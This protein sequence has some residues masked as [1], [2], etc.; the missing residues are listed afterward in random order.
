MSTM[1]NSERNKQMQ[2]VH[3]VEDIIDESEESHNLIK[4]IIEY[5]N[6]NEDELHF[7]SNSNQDLKALAKEYCLK[8]N[9]SDQIKN[10][11]ES[12][13]AST[14]NHNLPQRQKLR[15]SI[16]TQNLSKLQEKTNIVNTP[17]KKDSSKFK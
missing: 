3:Q 13:I 4:I 17:Q 2:K 8:N 9:L 6:G 16:N 15:L 7:S 11:L 5:E 1:L 12:L 14:L 10:Q